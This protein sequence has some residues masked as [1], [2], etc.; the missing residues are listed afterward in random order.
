MKQTIKPATAVIV[1]A[2]IVVVAVLVVWQLMSKRA[3]SGAPTKPGVGEPAGTSAPPGSPAF[4]GDPN[5]VPAS[6]TGGPA[7]GKM[8]TETQPPPATEGKGEKTGQT[9]G[10]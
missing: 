2:V 6:G 4:K 7:A 1:I 3:T 5:A 10:G 8:G 9:P